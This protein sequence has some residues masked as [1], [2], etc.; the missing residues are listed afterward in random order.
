VAAWEA[1]R[2]QERAKIDWRFNIETAR[3][4]FQRHYP[5]QS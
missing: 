4:K 5:S 1:R 2:N 3:D